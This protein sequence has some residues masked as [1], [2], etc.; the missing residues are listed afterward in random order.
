[1]LV[2]LLDSFLNKNWVTRRRR[3]SPQDLEPYYH[4]AGQFYMLRTDA[5]MEQ[6]TMLLK[7]TVPMICGEME[8]Q[9]I[10]NLEDWK[11]AEIKYQIIMGAGVQEFIPVVS[12]QQEEE[13]VYDRF[14]VCGTHP[15]T[16]YR[17]ESLGVWHRK[18][19]GTVLQLFF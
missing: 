2:I 13:D 14:F 6:H 3:L 8:V 18:R 15:G 9:D 16:V 1:M 11:L 17:A 12:N 5:M 10:D 19:R 4:D 7:E